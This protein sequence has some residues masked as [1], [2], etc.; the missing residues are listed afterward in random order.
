MAGNCDRLV[1]TLAAGALAIFV[2]GC[3]QSYVTPGKGAAMSRMTEGDIQ[4]QYDR[5]PASPF[6]AR[7]AVA[8]IQAPGYRSYRCESY[9]RGDYSV[10]TAHDIEKDEHFERLKKQPMVADVATLNRMI[11]PPELHN[12]REL[13][14]AAASLKTDIL[15]AYTID[16]TFYIENHEI[17]PLA[18][19]SLGFLPNKEARVTATASAVLLDV[20]TGYVYGLAEATAKETQIASY[21]T[22]QEAADASRAKAESKAFDQLLGELEKTWKGVVDQYAATTRQASAASR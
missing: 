1:S 19:I 15:L 13:R 11:I 5:E 8:R 4:A 12:N 21:W 7:L 16:T 20:R 22:T 10:V 14:I 18:L 6:P 2:A 3:S 17:G 9:G